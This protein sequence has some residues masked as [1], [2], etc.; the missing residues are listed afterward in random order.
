MIGRRS[1]PPVI[2]NMADI[3]KDVKNRSSN[4]TAADKERI[5][6]LVMIY[7]NVLENKQ[8]DAT[9]TQ[10]KE[11]AWKTVAREFNACSTSAR[12]HLVI[13]LFEPGFICFKQ[14]QHRVA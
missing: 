10:L 6:E 2:V 7:R 9:N 5:V 3:T 1:L 4:L 13:N 8:T 12:T 14:E 11:T